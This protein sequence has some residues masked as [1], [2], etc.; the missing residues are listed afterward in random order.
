MIH[1]IGHAAPA[2]LFFQAAQFDLGVTETNYKEFFNA[3]ST[4]LAVSSAAVDAPRFRL[5]TNRTLVYKLSC[6]QGGKSRDSSELLATFPCGFFAF[7]FSELISTSL[8][9]ID[10]YVEAS[11]DKVRGL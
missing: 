11:P 3:A 8:I 10:L 5:T 1:Y 2:R 9:E 7:R 6:S 4:T